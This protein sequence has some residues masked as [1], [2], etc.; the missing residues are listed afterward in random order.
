ME[1][2]ENVFTTIMMVLLFLL[3]GEIIFCG[4]SPKARYITPEEEVIIREGEE[5]MAEIKRRIVTATVYNPTRDQCDDDPTVTADN[6]KI[7]L[8]RLKN[9]EIKWIA[10]SRDLL[11]EFKYGDKVEIIHRNGDGEVSGVYEVH[12]TM[13]P[14]WRNRIDILRH[15]SHKK[16]K[17]EVEIRK[18]ERR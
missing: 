17:W 7:C 6:S 14:R 4:E 11:G 10:V 8:E 15:P 5:S 12:D 16:G 3:L 2:I 9:N 1:R 13:N 18:I